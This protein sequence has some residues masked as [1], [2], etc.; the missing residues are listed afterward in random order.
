MVIVSCVIIIIIG[1][2]ALR[3]GS[4]NSLPITAIKS[5]NDIIYYEEYVTD[6]DGVF[7]A[8]KDYNWEQ[9]N[10]KIN[11]DGFRS[12]EFNNCHTTKKK[13][14][15]LGD[16]FTWGCYA[17]PIDNSFVDLIEKQGYMTFNTGIPGVGPNQ[18]AFL[19]EKYVP[20]LKPD[21]VLVMICMANDI[22]DKPD[23]MLPNKNLYYSTNIGLISGFDANGRHLSLPEAIQ[24]SQGGGKLPEVKKEEGL[25]SLKKYIKSIVSQSM[26]GEKIYTG[27]SK[28]KNKLKYYLTKPVTS[29]GNKSIN[30]DRIVKT[31]NYN[32]DN[33]IINKENNYKVINKIIYVEMSSNNNDIDKLITKNQYV[34]DS[35]RRIKNISD[36]YS[37]RF[38]VFLIPVKPSDLSIY[39]SIKHNI[40]IFNAFHPLFPDNLTDGDYTV[41]GHHFNNNGHLKYAQFILEKIGHTQVKG[42]QV[43]D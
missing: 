25:I 19:A 22:N 39:N 38:M 1:E 3:V 10:I 29:D 2:I 15:F 40:S 21:Y 23:P 8:N 27:F 42:Q 30:K 11:S 16:S 26:L 41:I 35:L 24:F 12:R 43:L 36:K 18:Y 31:L 9:Q 5:P 4:V 6:K 37:A 20:I 28:I 7:K 17:N 32:K 34:I 13:I 33:K 14:L